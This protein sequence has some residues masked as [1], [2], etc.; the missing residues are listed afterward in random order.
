[1]LIV[2]VAVP[3][4]PCPLSRLVI[5]EFENVVWH[6]NLARTDELCVA[7][8]IKRASD[9][10]HIPGCP[11]CILLRELEITKIPFSGEW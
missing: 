2:T 1:M 7:W 8:D 11:F 4:C 10:I 9:H 5:N 3:M 6:P